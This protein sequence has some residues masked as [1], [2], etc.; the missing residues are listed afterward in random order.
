MDDKGPDAIRYGFIG[1]G[2]MGCEHIANVVA[3]PGATVVAAADPHGPSLDDARRAAG[4]ELGPGLTTYSDHREMLDRE[5]LDAVVVAT[6]NHTHRDVLRDVWGHP[7]LGVLIEK[8]LCTTVEDCVAVRDAAADHG[9]VVWMGL[10]YRYMPPVARFLAEVD[11]GAAGDVRSVSIREH[12]Y[13][14]LQ[15]VGDWNRFTRNTG[16]TLV[17]KCCHFFDLMN[18]VMPGRPVRVLASG[19]QDVNH[20]DE[21]YDGEVPDILDNAYVIVDYDDGRR[22]LLDLCMFAEGSRWE[23]ELVAVGDAGKVEVHVPGFMEV[24]RGRRGE[25]V[26]GSRGPEW[27]VD[28]HTIDTDERILFEGAHH[29]ASFLEHM[30][31]CEAI[32]AGGE[33]SVTVDEGLWS[34]AVGAA[35]HRSIEE[36]RPVTLAELGLG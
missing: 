2:M 14:F 3:L 11:G 16:G 9:G 25:L 21:S 18:L 34:V 15:K 4:P 22:A 5:A 20:L 29:G 8:P 23:Q 10:E 24:S 35:A 30:G 17:E 19:G 7:D 31:F 12:R 33:P 6:P 27:P 32:R 1:T 13:P 36:G 26:V 28:V